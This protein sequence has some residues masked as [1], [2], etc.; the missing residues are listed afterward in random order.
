M[1]ARLLLAKRRTSLMDARLLLA[2]RWTLEY[3]RNVVGPVERE[4][5]GASD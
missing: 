2:K 5:L 3:R 4:R 1:D